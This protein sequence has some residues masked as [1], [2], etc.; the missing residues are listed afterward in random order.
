M[1]NWEAYNLRLTHN[2]K[3]RKQRTQQ[4]LKDK[5]YSEI[6][7]HPG[8]VEVLVDDVPQYIFTK[9]TDAPTKKNF[10][11]LPGESMS[12]GSVVYWENRH[13]LVTESLCDDGITYHGSIE[14]CNRQLQWQNKQTREIIKRWCTIAKPY[15]SN[16]DEN[17]KVT[18]SSREFKV[19]L[20]ADD[21]TRL[22]DLD[23]K[24][25]IEVINGKPKCYRITSTDH[26]TRCYDIDGKTQGFL[27]LNIEQCQ[28]DPAT[29]SIEHGICDYLEPYDFLD[30]TPLG[31]CIVETESEGIVPGGTPVVFTAKY[32]DAKGLPLEEVKTVWTAE[33]GKYINEALTREYLEDGSLVLT[34]DDDVTLIGETIEVTA[35]NEEG[36]MTKTV[37][38]KVVNGL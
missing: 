16:L 34:L 20:P 5:L 31:W 17:L 35:M 28:Y 7:K 37:Q 25:M 33:G 22:L 19:Q 11:T 23:D 38:L 8:C 6:D 1:I 36:T 30:P 27:I 29:D 3:T 4:R 32:F 9:R 12:L 15:Y 10:N 13:W 14:Q 24:F 2:G 21:E 18:I 26:N